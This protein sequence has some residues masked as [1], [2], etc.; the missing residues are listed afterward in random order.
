MMINTPREMPASIAVGQEHS[1]TD[2]LDGVIGRQL[3]DS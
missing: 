2:P 1:R 3:V